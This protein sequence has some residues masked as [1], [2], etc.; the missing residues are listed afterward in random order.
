MLKHAREI[1][2]LALSLFLFVASGVALYGGWTIF[3]RQGEWVGGIVHNV[4]SNKGK[5]EIDL[6]LIVDRV[7]DKVLLRL[8]GNPEDLKKTALIERLTDRIV[9]RIVVGLASKEGDAL[10]AKLQKSRQLEHV[11]TKVVDHVLARRKDELVYVLRRVAPINPQRLARNLTSHV[12]SRQRRNLTRVL[13]KVLKSVVNQADRGQQGRLAIIVVDHIFKKHKTA[14]G[15]MLNNAFPQ[16]MKHLTEK[17]V[18]QVIKKNRRQ[19]TQIAQ[20]IVRLLVRNVSKKDMERLV[21]QVV[22]RILTNH[23]R[24]VTYIAKNAVSLNT[25][26]VAIRI[27]DRI[28]KH[29]RKEVADIIR[30]TVRIDFG[31]LFKRKKKKK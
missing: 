3:S 9:K 11:V 2:L 24:E 18:I 10:F 21:L 1:F 27:V 25:E 26:R 7:S 20:E 19:I 15:A 30:Q 31:S 6:P 12:L 17:L 8:M 28:M 14:I 29:H 5:K 23:K 16:D 22:R 13:E 4:L